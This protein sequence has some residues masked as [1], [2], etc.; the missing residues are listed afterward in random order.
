MDEYPSEKAIV[1]RVIGYT[2]LGVVLVT[3]IVVA[4]WAGGV[5]FAGVKGQGEAYKIKESAVNRIEKQ[6]MFEQLNADIDG[7]IAKI[8]LAKQAYARDPSDV[9][10]TNLNGVAQ[11]CIDTVQQYNAE[12]RKYTSRDFK[13]AGLPFTRDP[14]ECR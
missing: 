5:L 6:E 13:S 4:L 10:S 2:I 9:N 11:I 8:Q 14:A 1:G 12:S 3:L 7:Y